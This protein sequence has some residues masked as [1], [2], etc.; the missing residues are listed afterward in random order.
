[1][2]IIVGIDEA[3]R[4]PW[5]GS[6]F[7]GAVVLNPAA[8]ISGLNDSKKLSASQRERLAS[9]IAQH[10]L[11]W[12]VGSSSAAEVDS[13]NILQATFLAM[14]RALAGLPAEYRTANAHAWVDGNRDP[15]LGIPTTTIVQGDALIPAISAASILAKVARDAESHALHLQYP[16]YGFDKHKGYGTALHKTMLERLGPTPEHR[17]SFAPVARWYAAQASTPANNQRVIQP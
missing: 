4:G 13:V 7:A 5:T 10:A 2:Q 16:E 1:M 15:I 3:G 11:A 17:R 9:L 12:A 8:P 14:R 6:V